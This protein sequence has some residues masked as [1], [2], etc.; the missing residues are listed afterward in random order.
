MIY[1][2][3]VFDGLKK[4]KDNSVDMCLTDPPYFLDKLDNNWNEKDTSFETKN[5]II[6]SLPGGMRFNRD[7]GKK[8]YD[9]YIEVSKEIYRVLKPGAIYL[10]FS[11]QRLYHRM[12][13]AVE[14]AGFEIRDSLIWLYTQSQSKS[15]SVVRFLENTDIPDDKKEE[16]KE[17]LFYWKT[18]MLKSS[19]EPIVYGQ[20]PT[21]G[22]YLNNFYNYSVGMLN[23]N[24]KTKGGKFPSNTLTTEEISNVIDD[25]FLVSKPRKDSFNTHKTVKPTNLCEALIS[26]FTLEDAVI[27]DPFAGSGTT[28]VAAKNL[29]RNYIGIEVLKEY[30]DII[31]KR[32]SN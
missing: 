26:F 25:V 18:P 10:S 3:D 15:M 19:Y 4:I 2:C 6:K 16:L 27:L 9:W 14:D 8:L 29:N 11:A 1:N 22:T 21:D 12:T 32:L 7:Q 13:C 5:Q 28:L 17:L 24:E 31:N 23:T 20:K 30:V